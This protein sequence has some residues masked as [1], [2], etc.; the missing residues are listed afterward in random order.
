MNEP[1]R[2]GEPASA[3][4]VPHPFAGDQLAY[5]MDE[6]AAVS[7]IGRSALYLAKRDGRL[8]VRKAGRRSIVLRRD[9]VRFLED[10]PRAPLAR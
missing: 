2:A 4:D 7:G 6:A 1:T 9:L 10:L 3:T 5:S 8:P